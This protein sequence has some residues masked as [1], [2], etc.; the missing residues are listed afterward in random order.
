MPRELACSLAGS[1][2]AAGVAAPAS[3]LGR[4]HAAAHTRSDVEE[5]SRPMIVVREGGTA[6]ISNLAGTDYTQ[7]YAIGA[8]GKAQAVRATA[9]H[10][11]AIEL[12]PTRSESH[13][14]LQYRVELSK[15]VQWTEESE[16]TLANGDT[17]KMTYPIVAK[18]VVDSKTSIAES[19]C[20]A[21]MLSAT[22]SERATLVCVTAVPIE[23]KR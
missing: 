20:L 5:Y 15:L 2:A 14:G 19:E 4:A 9:E 18:R 3:L 10:G 22:D 17:V 6:E 8:D 13:V 16:R 7:D 12:K 21:V 23:S 1:G 11:L